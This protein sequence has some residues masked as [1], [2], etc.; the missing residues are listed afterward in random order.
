MTVGIV[1]VIAIPWARTWL[2]P[3]AAT[4]TAIA[5]APPPTPEQA[6]QEAALE[7]EEQQQRDVQR[8]ERQLLRSRRRSRSG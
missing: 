2:T 3:M 6:G 8:V 1:A 5:I 4:I 7:P